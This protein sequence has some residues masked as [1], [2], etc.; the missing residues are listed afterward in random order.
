MF[1]SE[2]VIVDISTAVSAG[3]VLLFVYLVL[4]MMA[5]VIE[6]F[7][8]GL[9][10][11]RGVGLKLAIGQLLG[12]PKLIG[13]G[14]KLYDHPLVRALGVTGYG[15]AGTGW[16]G[17]VLRG[18][19]ERLPSEIPNDLFADTLVQ[20]LE[21]NNAF[22]KGVM[23]P[24]LKAL[25]EAANHDLAVFRSKLIGWYATGMERQSGRYA[26][27]TQ[28]SLLLYGFLVAVVLNV[29]TLRIASYLVDSRNR[30][31]VLAA[32]D[33]I[34]KKIAPELQ[35][36]LDEIKKRC[37]REAGETE[38]ADK[39]KCLT[40]D[41]SSLIEGLKQVRG[42]LSENVGAKLPIGWGTTDACDIALRIPGVSWLAT[43]QI[44]SS[45]VRYVRGSECPNAA[46][47]VSKTPALS[48]APKDVG[49]A[50]L[51]GWL[52]T[53]LAVSLGSQFW[54]DLLRKLVAIRSSGVRQRTS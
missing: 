40:G 53:A 21:A 49:L 35:G 8:A 27:K 16:L 10:N 3:I 38:G 54:F 6:E 29:D 30:V 31:E 14:K 23:Q 20:I 50:T 32:A 4:A 44:G 52:L 39:A 1:G 15:P 51:I 33:R 17:R 34:E 26:R 46:E 2:G 45:V 42:A 11:S 7:M 19:V 18:R 41:Q 5:M 36:M 24:G 12:D 43:S 37:P 13:L 25:W 47:G 48:D 22:A 9:L 28:R